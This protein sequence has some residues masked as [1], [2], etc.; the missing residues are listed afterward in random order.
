MELIHSIWNRYPC[1]FYKADMDDWFSSSR[2]DCRYK[3]DLKSWF[4]KNLWSDRKI[5]MSWSYLLRIWFF[6][7][8][9]ITKCE[10]TLSNPLALEAA[11]KKRLEELLQSVH[12]HASLPPKLMVNEPTHPLSKRGED[13]IFLFKTSSFFSVSAWVEYL[14]SVKRCPSES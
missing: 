1:P 2:I 5:N 6:F 4:N 14:V 13:W 8:L 9:G 10:T 3:K 12:V 7:P 11:N